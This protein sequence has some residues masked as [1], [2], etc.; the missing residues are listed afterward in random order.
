MQDQ[1]TVAIFTPP[2]FEPGLMTIFEYIIFGVVAV[3]FFPFFISI[4]LYTPFYVF[5]LKKHDPDNSTNFSLEAW[6]NPDT[7]FS[8]IHYFC[9][10]KY[11]SLN[12]KLLSCHGKILT[13]SLGYAGALMFSFGS[14]IFI[15]LCFFEPSF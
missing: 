12:N 14:I 13:W 9:T 2:F 6:W 1:Q 4:W 5:L 3:T 8:V 7:Y 11:L 10:K 15:Y